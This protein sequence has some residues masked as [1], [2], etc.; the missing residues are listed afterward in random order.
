MQAAV[1][2]KH[3]LFTSG[4]IDVGFRF[5]QL[6][7]GKVVESRAQLQMIWCSFKATSAMGNIIVVTF[8]ASRGISI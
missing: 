6:T 1:V 7:L 5:F 8:V 2:P 3:E 4:G